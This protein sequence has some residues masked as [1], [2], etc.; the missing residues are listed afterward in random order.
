[1]ERRIRAKIDNDQWL[2]LASSD[3]HSCT[4]F[5]EEIDELVSNL[6]Y[7]L[8]RVLNQVS[9]T[10][11]SVRFWD[12][13]IRYWL[14]SFV[15]TVF[16]E[17]LDYAARDAFSGNKSPDK[18]LEEGVMRATHLMSSALATSQNPNWRNHLRN[19]IDTF[20]EASRG[21]DL[22]CPIRQDIVQTFRPYRSMLNRILLKVSLFA[23]RR[24]IVLVATYIPMRI[25][26]ALS[27]S[28]LTLPTKWFEFCVERRDFSSV[29]RTQIATEIQNES[30]Q[31]FESLIRA[32][33]PA[34]LPMSIVEQFSDFVEACEKRQ[35]EVPQLIFSDNLHFSSDSFALWAALQG[36]KGSLLAISQHG[37]LNGQGLFPTRDEEI[38][39]RI[40]DAYLHWG[41][42]RVPNGV[43]VPVLIRASHR[44]RFRWRTQVKIVLVTDTT[45]RF[46]RKYWS[47]SDAYKNLVLRTYRCLPEHLKEVTTVRLHRDHD[48]YD[49]SHKIF[50]NREFPRAILDD[51]FIPMRKLLRNARLVV[52][53]TFGTTEIECF[54]RNVP[55]VLSVD[56]I[57]HRPRPE[58]GE[59]VHLF[60]S[61]GLVHYSEESLRNFLQQHHLS[62]EVWWRSDA[63]Q[64]AI[65]R[66]LD[67]F[68]YRS[69]QPIRDYHKTLKAVAKK[70]D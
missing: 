14:I 59:F 57:L 50:W 67:R 18:Q 22:E 3:R 26:L 25:K 41:W 64:S 44:R 8:S 19:D 29:L 53:T 38:E 65:T 43:K 69:Q 60:E 33:L 28:F 35:R 48:R 11:Y 55:V 6:T 16:V 2:K 68:G 23:Q 34:Y 15:D 56:P 31:D 46:R 32:L 42:S 1:M 24:P 63:V 10:R 39:R 37:G 30:T 7:E 49:E 70:C 13:Y 12:R 66:Y 36:E 40:A 58:F 5:S 27:L 21:I 4:Q 17:W 20:L 54:L 9:G 62:I 45:F 52:C 61:V 47:D 51:G